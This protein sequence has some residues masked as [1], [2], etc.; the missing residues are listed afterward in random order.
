MRSLATAL[1]R[2]VSAPLTSLL[3]AGN[4]G[5]PLT[6]VAPA[7]APAAEA[8]VAV[9][10]AV[11]DPVQAQAVGP[12][13][14]NASTAATVAVL[15]RTSWPANMHA[16]IDGGPWTS[17]YGLAME[18]CLLPGYTDCRWIAVSG[19]TVRFVFNNHRPHLPRRPVQWDNN[20]GRDYFVGAPGVYLLDC[21]RISR[22]DT[23]AA[24]MPVTAVLY[25]NLRYTSSTP[26]NI[27]N[28]RFSPHSLV[29]KPSASLYPTTMVRGLSTMLGLLPGLP[30]VFDMWNVELSRLDNAA[31]RN[32]QI[33]RV[34]VFELAEQSAPFCQICCQELTLTRVGNESG[35]EQ[36]SKP[37]LCTH[38]ACYDCM[39][40]YVASQVTQ[41]K[42]TV[43]CPLPDCEFV[44]YADDIAAH[45]APEIYTMYEENSTRSFAERQAALLTDA[46]MTEYMADNETVFCPK[47]SVLIERSEG[48]DSMVCTCGHNFCFRC[49]N[50][51]GSCACDYY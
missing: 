28:I 33:D 47:C 30:G 42:L 49:K 11:E 32:Y 15:Y 48:C 38:Q 4:G 13:R 41:G 10:A 27:F 17:L 3:T 50:E 7:M 16:S 39:S 20:E 6:A 44:M 1:L 8:V 34:G 37:T 24:A 35:V 25:K 2:A 36:W 29:V 5:L 45:A 40:Q 23:D 46:E 51:S 21:G 43:P 19:S 26:N 12:V 18:P 22:L 9:Q 14:V 31:G